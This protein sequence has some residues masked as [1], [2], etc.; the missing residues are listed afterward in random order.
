MENK[1]SEKLRID[2][3]IKENATAVL[4]IG[5]FVWLIYSMVIMPIQQLKYDVGNII[6]NHLETIQNEQTIATAERKA[7]SEQLNNLTNE[8]VRLSTILEQTGDL[9]KKK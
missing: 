6:N 3:V 8:L 7:Q 2:K 5:G 1:A 9:E 4:S